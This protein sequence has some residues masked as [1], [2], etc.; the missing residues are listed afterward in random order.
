LK[1]SLYNFIIGLRGRSLVIYAFKWRRIPWFDRDFNKSIGWGD[2]ALSN[3][4]HLEPALA[5]QSLNAG[6]DFPDFL[7][8][9]APAMACDRYASTLTNVLGVP[10]IG[11]ASVGEGAR[12]IQNR[13]PP[14]PAVPPANW[15]VEL[16]LP[17]SLP[18]WRCFP[19]FLSSYVSS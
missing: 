2:D 4:P 16:G 9:D 13:S 7:I 15:I 8:L 11:L 18:P 1:R 3:S 12:E 10:T 6:N 14:R 19:F 17:S 5:L